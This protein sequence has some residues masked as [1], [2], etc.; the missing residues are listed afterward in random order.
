VLCKTELCK[1][2]LC[3]TELCKMELCKIEF[4]KTEFCKTELC[5]TERRKGEEEGALRSI[6][7]GRE[8][9]ILRG[10]EHFEALEHAANHVFY[11]VSSTSKH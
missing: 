2:E 3:K 4:C 8:S 6:G 1:T 10:F 5:K 9:R 11:K 7:T